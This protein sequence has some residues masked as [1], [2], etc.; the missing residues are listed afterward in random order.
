MYDYGGKIGNLNIKDDFFV[1]PVK[2]AR[3]EYLRKY[4]L[5]KEFDLTFTSVL[6]LEF[7]AHPAH[8]SKGDSGGR[9]AMVLKCSS[10]LLSVYWQSSEVGWQSVLPDGKI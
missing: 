8:F 2:Q 7:V 9:R 4:E 10:S 5:R 6:G 1:L 3:E